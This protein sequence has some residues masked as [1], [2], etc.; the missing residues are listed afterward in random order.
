MHCFVFQKLEGGLEFAVK[1]TL[2]NFLRP[3]ANQIFITEM[4]VGDS[5]SDYLENVTRECPHIKV[6]ATAYINKILLIQLT[7]R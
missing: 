4:T 2:N 3:N 5:I 7:Y 6:F 1:L